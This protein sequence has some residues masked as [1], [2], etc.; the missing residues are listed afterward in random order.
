MKLK[1]WRVKRKDLESSEA[2]G[3]GRESSFMHG[4]ESDI[5][6]AK[7]FGYLGS[8]TRHISQVKKQNGH[9]LSF[10]ESLGRLVRIQELFDICV[11]IPKLH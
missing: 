11:R 5:M 9:Q 3:L 7:K 2:E 1:D 6:D 8:E 4:T 10:G